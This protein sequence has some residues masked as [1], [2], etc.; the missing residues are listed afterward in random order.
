[1]SINLTAFVPHPPLIIP[2]IG[3]DNIAQ[4]ANTIQALEKLNELIYQLKIETLIIFANQDDLF[5]NAFGINHAS[6]LI[7]DFTTFGDIAKYPPYK[8]DI[9]LSY[10]IREYLETRQ[11]VVLYSNEKL[12]YSIAIPLFYLLKNITT[13]KV[14]PINNSQLNYERHWQFGNQIKD[15]CIN[16]NKRIGII[17]SG[18]LSHCLTV[19]APGGLSARGKE[20][21][22]FVL[23]SLKRKNISRLLDIDQQL[24]T[25]AKPSG[26]RSLI[27]LLGVLKNTQFETEILSYEYPLGIGYLTA[28]FKL[29]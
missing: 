25:E 23:D 19:E 2:E 15:C 16:S 8:N 12:H 29:Q 21:D 10:Q 9:E 13:T 14:I 24:I 7:A 4:V 20:F 17:A 5:D 26:Y 6:N 28:N 1:M 18:N 22:S 27:M 3:G 11:S